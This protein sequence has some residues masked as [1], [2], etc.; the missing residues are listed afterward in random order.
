VISNDPIARHGNVNHSTF[1]ADTV[2][3]MELARCDLR[4]EGQAL[5]L[6]THKLI[7]CSFPNY[8][9]LKEIWESADCSTTLNTL[10]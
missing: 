10:S 4:A 2:H 6:S 5:A 1:L 8:V 9:D 7:L 3:E